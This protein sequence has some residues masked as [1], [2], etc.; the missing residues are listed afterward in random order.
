LETR[1]MATG[2]LPKSFAVVLLGIL[3]LGAH[4][5]LPPGQRFRSVCVTGPSIWNMGSGQ[6][7]PGKVR[8]QRGKG[9]RDMLSI[10]EDMLTI[11]EPW[12]NKTKILY[13]ANLSHHQMTKY[14]ELLTERNLVEIDDG[15][16][17]TTAKGRELLKLLSRKTDRSDNVI[18]K[19]DSL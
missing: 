3:V 1:V 8:H 6:V 10:I 5:P 17:H 18:S 19:L 14:L 4:G 13:G 9:R 7:Q 2:S 16:Y 11:S 15:H 12:V